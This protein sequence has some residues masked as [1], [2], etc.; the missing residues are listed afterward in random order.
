ML[1]NEME[2][3][4]SVEILIVKGSATDNLLYLQDFKWWVGM[5]TMILGEVAN[6]A[7]Y[8]YAP[9]ILVTPLGASSVL[10]GAV[11]AHLLLNERI[12]T[13]GKIGCA[14][15]II[16]SILIVLHSPEEKPF[17]SVDEILFYALSPGTLQLSRL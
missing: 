6:F 9:A 3:C 13:D 17:H 11:L 14:L 2:V 15:C 4:G 7:A 10:V 16:G 5:S 12:G 1:R 8:S